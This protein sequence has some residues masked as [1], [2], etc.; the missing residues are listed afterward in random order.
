MF[1]LQAVLDHP[2]E[3]RMDGVALALSQILYLLDQARQIERDV[4]ALPG[5][6]AQAV[7]LRPRPGVEVGLVEVVGC[8]LRHIVSSAAACPS[9][10]CAPCGRASSDSGGAP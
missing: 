1:E 2:F 5:D 6:E 7:G 4:R 3:V 8:R 10:A 9:P